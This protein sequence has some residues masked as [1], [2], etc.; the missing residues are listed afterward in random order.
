MYRR[1]ELKD[2]SPIVAKIYVANT[3]PPGS[4]LV[5]AD[6]AERS[7]DRLLFRSSNSIGISFAVFLNSSIC[8]SMKVMTFARVT[9]N[10]ASPSACSFPH[11]LNG[12][13]NPCNRFAVAGYD[14]FWR[15][16]KG[17]RHGRQIEL[18]HGRVIGSERGFEHT[19]HCMRRTISRAPVKASRPEE[20]ISGEEGLIRDFMSSEFLRSGLDVGW[21]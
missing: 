20:E 17:G 5:F 21:M 3:R 7:A 9:S 4:I 14:M 6:G 10:D 12:Q 11:S 18:P 13:V 8:D 19:L 15:R 1:S 16:W 2:S